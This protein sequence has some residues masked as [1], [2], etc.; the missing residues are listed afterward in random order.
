MRPNTSLRKKLSMRLKEL[1]ILLARGLRI[2]RI[3]NGGHHFSWL[4]GADK[5]LQKRGAISIHGG[6]VFPEDYLTDSGAE[7]VVSKAI[8]RARPL[9]ETMPSILK[10]KKFDHLIAGFD[11]E[12]VT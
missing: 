10:I 5:V 8:A 1:S 2:R 11:A 7:K 9:D 6:E 12:A 3:R 4:G